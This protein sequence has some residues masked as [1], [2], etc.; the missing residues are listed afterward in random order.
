M[1]DITNEA[2]KTFDSL[3][4]KNVDSVDTN[5]R[6]AAY[7]S[8]LVTALRASS[9]YVAY[10]L[11]EAFRPV[12]PPWVITAAYAISWTYL[13][14]DVGYETF[15]AKRRGPTALEAATYT[16]PTRLT[17]V[18][19][20]RSVFQSV[21][22]MAL[23]AFTIHSVVRYAPRLFKN[24]KSP[25]VKAWG[26]TL[27]GLAVVPVLPYLYDHPVENVTEWAFDWIAE[28]VRAS[29]YAASA[30]ASSSKGSKEL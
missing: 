14:G 7:S 16:E 26:P 25:R 28:R 8:R 19:V 18:A 5:A 22:S 21:A 2:E 17:M 15:K 10:V 1:S 13:A 3:A 29:P 23:P 30:S 4:D 24:T 27:T 11:G 6:Y 12:A 20:Q 9:R